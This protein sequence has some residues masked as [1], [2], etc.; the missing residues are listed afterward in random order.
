MLTQLR[1]GYRKNKNDHLQA[2]LQIINHFHTLSYTVRKIKNMF[3]YTH[4]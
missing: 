1:E 4:L 2:K 3:Q